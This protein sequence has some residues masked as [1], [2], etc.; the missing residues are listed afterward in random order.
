MGRVEV[1]DVNPREEGWEDCWFLMGHNSLGPGITIS[2]S[3]HP[4]EYKI[5]GEQ[6]C[7][8]FCSGMYPRHLQQYLA[9]NEQSTNI[10]SFFTN[11]VLE[12]C[13]KGTQEAN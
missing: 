4:L 3:E 5:R 11:E 9:R 7:G 12:D 1:T 10:C 13:L 8:I 6:D 2:H